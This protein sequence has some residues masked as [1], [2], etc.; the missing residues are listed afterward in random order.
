MAVGINAKQFPVKLDSLYGAVELRT[1]DGRGYGCPLSAACAPPRPRA[2]TA[3]ALF[4]IK[5]MRH[6]DLCSIHLFV[7]NQGSI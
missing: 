3:T 1:A 5:A 7:S 4:P 6:A 2:T